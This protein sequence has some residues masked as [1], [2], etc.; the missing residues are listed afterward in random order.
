MDFEVVHRNVEFM[1]SYSYFF[2]AGYKQMKVREWVMAYKGQNVNAKES[3][4]LSPF[5]AE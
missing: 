4:S 3:I 5:I 1:T 2:Q